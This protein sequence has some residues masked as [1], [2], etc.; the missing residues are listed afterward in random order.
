MGRI[1]QRG[2]MTSTVYCKKHKKDINPRLCKRCGSY[3]THERMCY[4]KKPAKKKPTIVFLLSEGE[5][6]DY[7]VVGIYRTQKKAKKDRDVDILH[8][9]GG[10]LNH[11]HWKRTSEEKR[12]EKR[13]LIIEEHKYEY[14]ME[15][16]V[17]Q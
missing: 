14:E 15:E 5:Y 17:L 13:K 9:N 12:E 16:F 7:R 1:G 2:K 6:S 10:V 8:H 11:Y 3:G 4:Y